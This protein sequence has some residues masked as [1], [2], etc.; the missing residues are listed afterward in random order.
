M[1]EKTGKGS[2]GG[3]EVPC[4]PCDY[5]KLEWAA[6]R[7]CE[8]LRTRLLEL[9]QEKRTD[10]E[11]ELLWRRTVRMLTD[12]YY[13]QR[14][15]VRLFQKRAEERERGGRIIPFPALGA[16]GEEAFRKAD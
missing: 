7:E 9:K 6:R 12:M 1:A 16:A 8:S 4:S 3:W 10:G 5:R 2:V 11:S 14:A 15:N 13:E